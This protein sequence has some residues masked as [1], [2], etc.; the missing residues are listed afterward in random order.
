MVV[1]HDLL[2]LD[3]SEIGEPRE[4]R[5][6]AGLQDFGR[7]RRLPGLD[8]VTLHARGLEQ[9]AYGV[10]L[11]VQFLADGPCWWVHSQ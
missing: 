2:V 1:V 8:H 7:N 9:Y 11:Q 6:R 10:L 5:N 4:K 3:L